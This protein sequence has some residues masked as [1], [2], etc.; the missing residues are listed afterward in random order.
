MLCCVVVEQIPEYCT[1][2][3][4]VRRRPHKASC[5]SFLSAVILNPYS[6]HIGIELLTKYDAEY[7][8]SISSHVLK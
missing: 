2:L 4:L 3:T 1:V 8:G 5:M 6:R 7:D